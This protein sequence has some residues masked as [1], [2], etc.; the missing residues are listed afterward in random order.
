[1]KYKFSIFAPHQDDEFLGC[2]QLIKNYANCIDN[3]IFFTNGER[4]VTSFPDTLETIKIR[5]LESESWICENI[6]NAD[7]HYLNIPDGIPIEEVNLLY[8]ANIFEKI[9][10]Q[11]ILEHTI[12]KVRKFIANNVIVCPTKEDHPS[13]SLTTTIAEHFINKKI[14]Y[15]VHRVMAKRISSKPGLY[16]K[17][18]ETAKGKYYDY[19]YVLRDR[20][21]ITKR[22]EFRKYYNSQYESFLLSNMKLQNLERYLSPLVLKLT[23]E[24][25]TRKIES[26]K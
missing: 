11:T 12:E 22:K 25:R 19:F 21:I 6:P 4:S 5:R 8:G 7:I 1:M 17:V 20:E 16:F 9:H 23:D 2:R 3:V 10:K 18:V 13:H 24:D 15:D 14:Y 26:I